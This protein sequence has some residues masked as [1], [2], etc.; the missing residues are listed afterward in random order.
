[1]FFVGEIGRPAML[2]V[3]IHVALGRTELTAFVPVSAALGQS[4]L[5]AE[6]GR[7]AAFVR[8]RVGLTGPGCHSAAV[9]ETGIVALA[10]SATVVVVDPAVTGVV[11][12]RAT[13][14]IRLT[15]REAIAVRLGIAVP[16]LVRIRLLIARRT[17]REQALARRKQLPLRR[18]V[19]SA[20]K[21][22]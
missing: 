22:S 19:K 10:V 7:F 21:F 15:R 4:I 14:R 11:N 2:G 6:V 20:S 18:P 16:I 13:L 8:V 17:G 5:V 9:T 1:M 12:A 3:F